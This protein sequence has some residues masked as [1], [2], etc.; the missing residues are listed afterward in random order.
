[1]EGSG[2]KVRKRVRRVSKR[3]R[4]RTIVEDRKTKTGM[5]GDLLLLESDDLSELGDP[6]SDVSPFSSQGEGLWS[7]ALEVSEERGRV[8]GKGRARSS[9]SNNEEKGTKGKL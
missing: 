8:G 3:E 9:G 7:G 4:R 6:E 2:Q 1:M 5:S